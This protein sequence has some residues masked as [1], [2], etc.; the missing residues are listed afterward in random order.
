MS[1]IC[2]LLLSTIYSVIVSIVQYNNGVKVNPYITQI[3][4]IIIF[5]ASGIVYG[6]INKKQG[7]LGSL[8]F[9]LV[10]ALFLIIFNIIDKNNNTISMHWLFVSIK[11]LT[12]CIGAI[13]SVNFKTK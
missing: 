2:L 12:Y 13:L 6:L 10:Y 7:L 9:I 11:C 5:F 4:S 3:I 8:M 1:I